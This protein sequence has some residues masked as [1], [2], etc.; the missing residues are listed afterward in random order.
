[1]YKCPCVRTKNIKEYT[2]LEAIERIQMW[3]S[4]FFF[5]LF[6]VPPHL[7]TYVDGKL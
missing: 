3:I 5:S 7:N 6:S 4:H 2:N 1:M